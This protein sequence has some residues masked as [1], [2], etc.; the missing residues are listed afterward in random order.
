MIVK[1]SGG[2]L[3]EC[4]Q[5]IKPYIDHWTILDTGSID[6]TQEL[7]KS[8]LQDVPGNLYEEPFVNFLVS[9]N[10]SLDLS[11]GT[12]KYTI[13]L[14]DS[15]CINN[16]PELREFLIKNNGICYNIQ[17][18]EPI[19]SNVYYSNRIIRTD[20]GKRYEKY[21][22][23]EF[24]PD[25]E[26]LTLPETCYITDI[27][28]PYHKLRS[29]VRFQ[30]DL[31]LLKEHYNEDPND[32]RILYYIAL[33]NSIIGNADEALRY[34]KKILKIKTA[35]INERY[36]AL[37]FINSYKEK[38]KSWDET[39]KGLFAIIKE[40][41]YRM[42]PVFKLFMHEYNSANY[43]RAFKY[44]QLCLKV[45]E[46]KNYPYK[47][48][49]S[50]Y[51]IYIPYFYIDLSLKLGFIQQGVDALKK[52]LKDRPYDQR[53]L[54]IKYQ[55]T[56]RIF[57]K[58]VKL[59]ESRTIVIHTGKDILNA[60]WNPKNIVTLGSGS[61]IMAINLSKKLVERGY[62]VILFGFFKDE[63]NNYEGKYEGVE[64]FDYTVF[65][66]FIQKYEVD[67]LIVSRFV[68]NMV[69]YDNVK[70]VY[71]WVHD[72]LP[73]GADY[74]FQTHPK[75]FKGL[76][77]LS[78]WHKDINIKSF[79]LP[80]NMVKTTHN[81]I[82]VSRFDKQIEKEP[83]RFI[84]TSDITRGLEWGIKMIHKIHEKYPR[85]TLHIFG[86]TEMI[87]DPVLL[88][89][90]KT[91][92]YIVVHSRVSQEELAIEMLK[93]EYWLY[94]NNFSETYCISAVEAQAANCIV[95]TNIQAGLEDTV[96]NRGITVS[97]NMNEKNMEN[98]LE[99][100]YSVME[101]PSE[102]EKLK[103][104]GYIYAK[105]QTFE[106]LADEWIKNYL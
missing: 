37:M 6:G 2:I 61:E 106:A 49:A 24:I 9:R 25:E 68:E 74:L 105:T 91:T 84:W 83:Y 102:K 29:T 19:T 41:P 15:Y 27:S 32:T 75:K 53:L 69:Y 11:S 7:V 70:K 3:Q 99:K 95:V 89:E 55:I 64:Y 82:H 4:L 33:T 93:S 57:P 38:D 60:A 44:I 85:A 21:R 71:L 98:L 34:Y 96:G 101:N 52:T 87:S 39:E 63:K 76:L 58:A 94:P 79:N 30:K 28:D 47:Y 100:L 12:C 43:N 67:C 10:R 104:N 17:I 66:E 26:Y 18:V 46:P 62:R 80:E 40:F 72:V 8:V 1:N 31:V 86:K 92:P 5:K 36:E 103:T 88:N 48:D 22:I 35:G 97:G 20:T 73:Q 16:G 45:K 54:N 77:C 14:D 65:D 51:R 78:K 13:I 59:S 50:I 81:A 23:H 42:E 56:D 90:I